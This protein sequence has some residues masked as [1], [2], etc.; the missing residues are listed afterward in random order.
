MT[1][2]TRMRLKTFRVAV[3]VFGAEAEKLAA[4]AA[5][6]PSDSS[7]DQVAKLIEDAAELSRESKSRDFNWPA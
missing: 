5:R 6:L 2:A 4:T 7:R 3:T 1:D